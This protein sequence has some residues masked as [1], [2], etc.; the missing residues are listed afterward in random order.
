MA[1]FGRKLRRERESRNFTLEQVAE[2]TRI[3][4]RYLKALESDDLSALPGSVFSKG[5][6]RS[7][8]N[9]VG[10]DAEALVQAYVEEE[11]FQ[12]REGRISRPDVMAGL[13]QAAERN[14]RRRRAAEPRWR[15]SALAL[16]AVVL[17]A[18]GGW[19]L[20]RFGFS[21]DGGSATM[22]SNAVQPR[23]AQP[24]GPPPPTAQ[25]PAER[26]PAEES[27]IPAQTPPAEPA[28]TSPPPPSVDG[29][30][31]PVGKRH[32]SIIE[33]GV[34]TGVVD[35]QL[36]GR[37]DR[38]EAGTRVW[39]WNRVAGGNKGERIRHVWLHEG[40]A[41]SSIELILGGDHWRTQ[42][43]TTL[44]AP[45]RWAVEARDAG[46]RVLARTEFTS[47]GPS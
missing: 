8:A 31:E 3:S 26:T 6:V 46:N 45:G 19:A 28:P 15:L 24:V 20:V 36:V 2:A 29:A 16:L 42:S 13:A 32:V 30:V 12:E 7:F 21:S 37:S 27:P 18:L 47:E 35:W 25:P 4:P 40:Q 39:F 38:F 41:V 9:F 10:A 22:A 34:G 33:F 44:R 5:Y 17:V 11:E 43:R 14:P 1:G 23:G